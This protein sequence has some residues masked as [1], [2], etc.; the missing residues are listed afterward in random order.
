LG[1]ETIGSTGLSYWSDDAARKITLIKDARV[2][3]TFFDW[4]T[5]AT[6]YKLVT[7]EESVLGWRTFN[8]TYI[9]LYLTSNSSWSQ[10]W[11]EE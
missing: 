8:D 3:K 2:G 9:P 1:T 5:E 7:G 4:F 10:E 11:V 6:D